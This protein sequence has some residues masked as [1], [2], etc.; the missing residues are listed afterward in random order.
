MIVRLVDMVLLLLF[1]F[2]CVSTLEDQTKVELPRSTQIPVAEKETSEAFSITLDIEGNYY[3]Q[4]SLK[5]DNAD[6]VLANLDEQ[7]RL[8]R[9]KGQVRV[10]IR[11]DHGAPTSRVK[12][13]VRACSE[14]N[15]LASLV[16]I[17]EEK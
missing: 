16:I 14:R 11:A 1:G 5:P 4:G 2:I 7:N 17:K 10:L 9:R 15:M 12:D 8:W 3:I 6:V 13:L